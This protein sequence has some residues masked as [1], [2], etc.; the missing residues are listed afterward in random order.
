MRGRTLPV[1]KTSRDPLASPPPLT[2]RGGGWTVRSAWAMALLLVPGRAAPAHTTW[3]LDG[4]LDL[5]YAV[6]TPSTETSR[7]LALQ[8]S[9]GATLQVESPRLAW[10]FGYRF[11]GSLDLT[12]VG[13][14]AYAN[15]LSLGL[16][17]ALT[18]R[19]VALVSA[20]VG[21]GGIAY[22]LSQRPAD[23]GQ[24]ALRAPGNL[25][26]VRASLGEALSWEASPHLRLAETVTGTVVAPQEARDQYNARLDGSFRLDRAFATDA[27]GVELASSVAWLQP[28]TATGDRYRTVANAL[29]ASWRRD[30]D[31]RWSGNVRAGV[32]QVVAYTGS[33]PLAVLP[34]GDLTLG[35]RGRDAGGAL[36]VAYGASS[37]LETGTLAQ[38]GSVTLRGS[39]SFDSVRPRL[40]SASAGYLRSRPLG[41]VTIGVAAGT[42]DA[43]QADVGLVWALWGDLL[44]TARS[45]VAYQFAQPAG[46]VRSL[47]FS[48]TVGVA[49]R[50]GN[51][52]RLPP[53]PTPGQ[54]VDR[55]DAVEFS[56]PGDRG[57]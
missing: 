44:G 47:V 35:Y 50:Y 49:F 15:D 23:A 4:A 51:A 18:K 30:L 8:L 28:R 31:A 22:V 34:V 27:L 17:A 2:R 33:V 20:S 1:K 12:G 10:R 38:A 6:T 13:A 40:L 25:A 36:A 5:S 26:M 41:Q 21:Q 7:V 19:S 32:A 16:A 24:P 42:G 55:S 48:I 3:L 46:I 11:G 57:P 54:R 14:S 45:S 9:P 39:L 53:M 43:V 29:F 56:R 37:D 52:T